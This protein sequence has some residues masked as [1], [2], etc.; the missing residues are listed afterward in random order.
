MDVIDSLT[1]SLGCAK[2][3]QAFF[4][5]TFCCFVGACVFWLDFVLGVVWVLA[6]TFGCCDCLRFGIV[7]RLLRWGP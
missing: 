2:L 1:W 3:C 6:W 5:D 7:G 4:V